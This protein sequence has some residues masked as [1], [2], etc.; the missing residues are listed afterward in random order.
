M[1]S[2]FPFELNLQLFAINLYLNKHL[3]N[4]VESKL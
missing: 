1:L 2:A 4:I 3:L